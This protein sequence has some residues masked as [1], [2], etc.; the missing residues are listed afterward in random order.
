MKNSFAPFMGIPFALLAAAC[1]GKVD[2][3]GGGGAARVTIE[4]QNF[5]VG[6]VTLRYAFGEGGYFRIEGNDAKHPDKECLPGLSG[7][8]ALYGDLPATI[9]SVAELEGRELPFEFTG[10][11][12]EANLCFVGSNGLLGVEDGVVRFTAVGGDKVSFSFSGDF[13]VYDGAGG[14]PAATSASGTGEARALHD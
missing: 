3:T 6:D 2:A 13:N 11:G 9:T 8:L 4:T 14:E 10:D 5:D 1:G 12:D 7:G